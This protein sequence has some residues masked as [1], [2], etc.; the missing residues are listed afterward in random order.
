MVDQLAVDNNGL[1]VALRL[2]TG[3]GRDLATD[4]AR[5]ELLA[6]LGRL[7]TRFRSG[8]L[9]GLQ[10]R[11]RSPQYLRTPEEKLLSCITR[12]LRFVEGVNSATVWHSEPPSKRNLRHKRSMRY[13]GS[14]ACLAAEAARQELRVV[15]RVQPWMHHRERGRHV[16]PLGGRRQR[17]GGTSGSRFRASGVR[18]QVASHHLYGCPPSR[19]GRPPQR[20]SDSVP[21]R[22][23]PV[24]SS[25]AFRHAVD[26]GGRPCSRQ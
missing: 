15:R 2:H 3:S 14:Q 24:G 1:E 25:L 10:A 23:R 8:R 6:L 17:E 9:W 7:N 19:I 12:L 26:V 16:V 4:R 18:P 22:S 13:R 21:Q 20:P 5:K 11:R